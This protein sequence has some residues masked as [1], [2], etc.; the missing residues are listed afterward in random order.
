MLKD[1]CLLVNSYE[2]SQRCSQHKDPKPDGLRQ[3]FSL[4]CPFRSVEDPHFPTPPAIPYLLKTFFLT[5]ILILNDRKQFTPWHPYHIPFC[6]NNLYS[7]NSSNL[8]QW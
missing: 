5:N 1:L 8:K 6:L 2:G 4:S 7:G 3:S